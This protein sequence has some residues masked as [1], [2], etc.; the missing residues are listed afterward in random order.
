M[1]QSLMVTG[2]EKVKNEK[3]QNKYPPKHMMIEQLCHYIRG[4]VS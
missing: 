4:I 3:Y 2:T 1:H